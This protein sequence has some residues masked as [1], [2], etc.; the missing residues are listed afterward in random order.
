M[1]FS[2][3]NSRDN[4]QKIFDQKIFF[5]LLVENNF[6]ANDYATIKKFLPKFIQEITNI[7]ENN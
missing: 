4:T 5:D 7:L 2:N 6:R 3:S 1:P